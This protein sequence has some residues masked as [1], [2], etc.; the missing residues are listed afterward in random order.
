MQIHNYVPLGMCGLDLIP[1]I[2][3]TSANTNGALVIVIIDWGITT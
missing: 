3:V 1:P 2:V